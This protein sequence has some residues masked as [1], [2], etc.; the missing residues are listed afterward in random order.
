MYATGIVRRMDDLG[1]VVIP[2]ELRQRADIKEG[3]ALEVFITPDKMVVFK[4]YEENSMGMPVAPPTSVSTKSP[5]T[6]T[7]E[8]STKHFVLL[9]TECENFLA[10]LADNNML[11]YGVEWE[12][13]HEIEIE[14]F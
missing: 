10:W 12:A 8:D 1:R 2:K 14:E 7:D 3:D 6:I 9:S 4:K 5:Y 11:A 13:G